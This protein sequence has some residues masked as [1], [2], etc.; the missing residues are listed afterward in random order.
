MLLDILDLKTPETMGKFLHPILKGYIKRDERDL[1]YSL[2]GTV[3][4]IS[5]YDFFLDLCLKT[6]QTLIRLYNTCK[7]MPDDISE[8]LDILYPFLKE[9]KD[10]LTPQ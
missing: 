3:K 8:T 6:R 9:D 4:N 7:H 1:I 10:T 5:I 2:K